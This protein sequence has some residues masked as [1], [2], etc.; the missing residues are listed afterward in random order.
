[1]L[2]TDAVLFKRISGNLGQSI[3]FEPVVL[4][5]C[6][7]KFQKSTKILIRSGIGKVPK[8]NKGSQSGFP[9]VQFG[10]PFGSRGFNSIYR[11]G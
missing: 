2:V 5:H 7:C 10:L 9:G 1:M 8:K 11:I 3:F 4:F 6:I